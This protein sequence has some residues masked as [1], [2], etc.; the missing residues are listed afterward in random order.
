MSRLLGDDQIT[1]LVKGFVLALL[2]IALANLVVEFRGRGDLTVL[3]GA[4]V[5][6]YVGVVLAVG[7]FTDRLFAPRTQIALFCGLTLYWAYDYLEQGNTL[8]IL[9][10]VL[11]LGVLV[12]QSRRLMG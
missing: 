10:V 5:L 12:Q 6:V 1:L 9:L 3:S 11:G 2:A 8:S 7:V 4:L